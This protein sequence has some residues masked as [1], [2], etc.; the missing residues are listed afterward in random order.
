MKLWKTARPAMLS[1]VAAALLAACGGGN[2][3]QEPQSALLGAQDSLG[4]P[5]SAVVVAST[6]ALGDVDG[7]MPARSA[8]PKYSNKVW[9]VQLSEPPASGYTG[10][11]A[12]LAATK[13]AHGA[14]LNRQST[15]VVS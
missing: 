14:K 2:N 5:Q 6:Q 10:G 15:A 7:K 1:V 11:I 3:P 12:G 8:P 9:I 4:N 13:P